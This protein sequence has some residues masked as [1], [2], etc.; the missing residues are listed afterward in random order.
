MNFLYPIGESKLTVSPP[1]PESTKSNLNPLVPCTPTP[2]IDAV[3]WESILLGIT[4]NQFKLS[5]EGPVFDVE[6]LSKAAP[7]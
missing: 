7:G 3:N 5:L 2:W 6:P 4:S 1:L